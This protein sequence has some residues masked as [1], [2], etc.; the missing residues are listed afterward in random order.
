MAHEEDKKDDM[1]KAKAMDVDITMTDKEIEQEMNAALATAWQSQSLPLR[2]SCPTE[3]FSYR[4]ASRLSY[5]G[6][7]A[8]LVGV[9]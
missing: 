3:A 6:V 2:A 5:R 9:P 7:L 8:F 1:P 4:L